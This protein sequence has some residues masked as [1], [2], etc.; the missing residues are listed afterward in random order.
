MWLLHTFKDIRKTPTITNTRKKITIKLKDGGNCKTENVVYVAR[1]KKH[2]GKSLADRFGKHRSYI[3]NRPDN[4][5]LA[6]Y[7]HKSHDKGDLEICILQSG[8]KSPEEREVQEEK[9]MCKLQT[10]D[11]TGINKK[12]KHYVKVYVHHTQT[13]TAKNLQISPFT[14]WRGIQELP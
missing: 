2:T 9:W 7:F 4:Y 10:L 5:E 14:F 13:F 3:K 8:I 12:V 1:C 6:E 11:P